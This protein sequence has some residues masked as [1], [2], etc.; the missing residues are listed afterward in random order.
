MLTPRYDID[1]FG[2]SPEMARE[3]ESHQDMAKNNKLREGDATEEAIV[4]SQQWGTSSIAKKISTIIQE[5]L[6][7]DCYQK[8]VLKNDVIWDT[9][10]IAEALTNAC[11]RLGLSDDEFNANYHDVGNEID[12]RLVG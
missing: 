1:G 4:K 5:M 2:E 10:T 7:I 11:I 6:E 8:L 3:R 12:I 9:E